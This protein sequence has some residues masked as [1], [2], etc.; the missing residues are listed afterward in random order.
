M[1][2]VERR[3]D[4]LDLA[5]RTMAGS[6]GPVGGGQATPPGDDWLAA[7]DVRIDPRREEPPGPGGDDLLAIARRF[8]AGDA[9][10]MGCAISAIR[11]ERPSTEAPTVY[12]SLIARLDAG[13][14]ARLSRP[15]R[16]ERREAGSRRRCHTCGQAADGTWD[17][18][19]PRWHHGHDPL[20]GQRWT[21]P[22]RGSRVGQLRTCPACGAEHAAGT[23]CGPAAGPV[24]P[25][26]DQPAPGIDLVEAALA[27]FGDDIERVITVIDSTD[28]PGRSVDRCAISARSAKSPDSRC[29]PRG[30]SL[31]DKREKREKGVLDAGLI[32]LLAED[33][34]GSDPSGTQA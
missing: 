8:R 12:P 27:I 30:R 4:L 25:V 23:T 16:P 21:M 11:G 24:L 3:D 15:E 31:R 32:P 33:V 18:G 10:D 9:T 13:G 26:A 2:E 22:P 17:D 7:P 5:R 6:P 19:S 20:T 28:P 1:R 14:T 29:R 34:D